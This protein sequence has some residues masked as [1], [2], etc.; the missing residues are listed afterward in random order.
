MVFRV[1]R[2]ACTGSLIPKDMKCANQGRRFGQQ[3]A[4]A[5]IHRMHAHRHRDAQEPDRELTGRAAPPA[6]G[7][8]CRELAPAKKAIGRDARL[9]VSDE[10]GHS[11]LFIVTVYLGR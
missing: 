9:V 11:W 2:S 4:R 1:S 6:G 8:E 7:P 3:C 10:L 5:G